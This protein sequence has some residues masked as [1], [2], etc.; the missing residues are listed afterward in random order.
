M[1]EGSSG[2]IGHG[3]KHLAQVQTFS[4]WGH[5]CLPRPAYKQWHSEAVFQPKICPSSKA[6]LTGHVC[7]QNLTLRRISLSSLS[8]IYHL[9]THTC[10]CIYTICVHYVYIY[11]TH[12][13]TYIF[14]CKH[15]IL[16]G[17]YMIFNFFF[18]F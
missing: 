10:V 11:Y 1:E 13:Y 14:I 6:C 2:R 17:K 8:I 7:F 12:T 5:H 18:T 9:Y 3:R 16:Y 4:T 15:T